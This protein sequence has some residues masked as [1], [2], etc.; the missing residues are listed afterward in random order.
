MQLRGT[1]HPPSPR[2]ARASTS[3]VH[4]GLLRR[5]APVAALVASLTALTPPACPAQ[6]PEV[7]HRIDSTRAALWSDS[8][9]RP[10]RTA[11]ATARARLD[12]SG[13]DAVLRT[14]LGWALLRTGE[15]SDSSELILASADRFYEAAESEPLWPYPWYGLGMA[16]SELA[17]RRV[18]I[19]FPPHQPVGASWLEAAAIAFH[20]AAQ[21]DPTYVPAATA[22]GHVV[23]EDHFAPQLLLALR[24]LRPVLDSTQRDPDPF[25]VLGRL[26]FRL[27]SF[28]TAHAGFQGYL[29]RGGDSAIGQFEDSR[30][31]FALHR[32]E[33][34]ESEYYAGAGISSRRTDS[35]YRADLA[36]IAD[37][38]ELRTY[39]TLTTAGSRVA[40]LH[41]FWDRRDDAASQRRGARLAEHNRRWRYAVRNFPFF[42]RFKA[43]V[44]TR[45]F[46]STQRDFDD[47]GVIYLRQ[48]EPDE[49]VSDLLA[50]TAFQGVSPIP[51]ESWLY[52][53]ADGN[54]E[55]HF[56]AVDPGGWALLGGLSEIDAGAHDIYESRIDFGPAYMELAMLAAMDAG[57]RAVGHGGLESLAQN[58]MFT[59]L[60]ARDSAVTRRSIV[61]GTTTDAF[62]LHYP[63]PLASIIQT[64]GASSPVSGQAALLVE[65]A[66][67]DLRRV[68]TRTLPDSSV[69]YAL[70]LRVQAADS[71]GH[72]ALN[73]DSVRLIHAHRPLAKGQ[74]LIG[75]SLLDVPPDEYRVKVMISDTSD[76]IGAAWAVAGIPAPALDGPALTLSD[77]ILG[78]E[79][80]GLSWAR[81]DGTIPLNPLNE[82]PKGVTATLSYEVGGLTP[83]VDY[84]TR[85][86]VRKFGADSTHNLIAI[87]FPNVA[88]TSR[89][90]LIRALGLGNLSPGRYL[91]VLTLRQGP[92]TVTRSRRLVIGK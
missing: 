27:D 57:R 20:R 91:L 11:L 74:T 25:L 7:R 37:T 80:S 87:D 53:R 70:R 10:L 68:P 2:D 61:I 50:A 23:L 19:R 35:V 69:V 44:A 66:L 39:D 3:R 63:E 30:A 71:A 60:L 29:A 17:A 4:R 49:R 5:S 92:R 65:Y 59:V 12:A 72:L 86:A 13:H 81:P 88:T 76:S 16:K 1:A 41:Q 32:P 46:M 33:V 47:R 73:T 64:Y 48:G 79:G 24:Q 55:F 77:P 8:S 18:P 28:A 43:R 36:W 42:G 75:F 62:P 90:L 89:A 85:I 67:P 58:P 51:N 15:V 38:G 82:Y 54:L 9:I 6:S 45:A 31:L 40:W 83:G 52:F 34:A 78:R 14:T 22:L 56:G 21:A 84:S 26:A